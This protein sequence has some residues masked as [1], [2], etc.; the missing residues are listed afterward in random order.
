MKTVKFSNKL[1][2]QKETIV[3]LN[4]NDMLLVNGGI[5]VKPFPIS[6][7]SKCLTD[8]ETNDSAPLACCAAC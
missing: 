3:D 1:K 6:D 4:N 2:L 7:F 5:F 8:C